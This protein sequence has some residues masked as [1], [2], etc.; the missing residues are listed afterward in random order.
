MKLSADQLNTAIKNMHS[1]NKYKQMVFYV[2]ACESGSMFD[3]LL[4]TDINGM[5]L[6]VA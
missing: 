1:Q 4:A 6:V 3:K 5:I 2:E